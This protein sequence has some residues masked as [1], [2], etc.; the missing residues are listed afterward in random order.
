MLVYVNAIFR[1]FGAELSS[2]GGEPFV[3]GG[4]HECTE[5]FCRWN[6]FLSGLIFED[7][8]RAAALQ[9]VAFLRSR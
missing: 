1:V 8:T 5:T 3:A 4:V 7:I 6:T 9:R 2:Q